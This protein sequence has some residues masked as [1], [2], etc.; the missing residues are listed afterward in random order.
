MSL[1]G[2][3]TSVG[4]LVLDIPFLL[5]VRIDRYFFVCLVSILVLWRLPHSGHST[6]LLFFSP[7]RPTC[8]PTGRVK[9]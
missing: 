2:S 6:C 9:R 1:A 3:L 4:G 7:P 8:S 5:S